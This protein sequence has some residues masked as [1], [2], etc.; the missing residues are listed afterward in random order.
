MAEQQRVVRLAYGHDQP[1]PLGA[2][3]HDA[4]EVVIAD[5]FEKLAAL[6]SHGDAGGVGRR[7]RLADGFVGVDDAVQVGPGAVQRRMDRVSGQINWPRAIRNLVT[8]QRDPHQIAS[9]DL[10]VTQPEGIDQEVIRAGNPQGDVIVDDA[11]PAIELDQTIGRRQ[12]QSGLAIGGVHAARRRRKVGDCV[13][14]RAHISHLLTSFVLFTC[15]TSKRLRQGSCACEAVRWAE[16]P[17]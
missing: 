11:G 6:L 8:G 14:E 13:E 12:F 4:F 5:A 3:E 17:F 10:V 2:I 15:D 1:R 9:R 16:S 7:Q